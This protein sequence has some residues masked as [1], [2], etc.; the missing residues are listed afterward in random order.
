MVNDKGFFIPKVKKKAWDKYTEAKEMRSDKIDV[1]SVV[2]SLLTIAHARVDVAACMAVIYLTASRIHEI[3]R[4]EYFSKYRQEAISL[5]YNIIKPGF[6]LQQL[7]F[8]KDENGGLWWHFKTINL[9]Q[10]SKKS[11]DGIEIRARLRMVQTTNY[12]EIRL[13]AFGD[14]PDMRLLKFVDMYFDSVLNV[15]RD[16]LHDVIAKAKPDS[17]INPF[18]D[19]CLKDTPFITLKYQIVYHYIITYMQMVL[20][21]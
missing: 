6:E 21:I 19:E 5:G 4:W 1:E 10:N 7:S 9:K 17:F 14:L 11:A 16:D 18:K 3:I 15:Y 12:K 2:S 13:P 20:I 8:Y